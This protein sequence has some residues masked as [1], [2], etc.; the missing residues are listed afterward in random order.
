MSLVRK[1]KLKRLVVGLLRKVR[2]IQDTN[3]ETILLV[4]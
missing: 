1:T 3:N 2:V 4:N